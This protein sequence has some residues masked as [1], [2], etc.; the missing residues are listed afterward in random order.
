MTILFLIHKPQA[1]GQELFASLL[2]N[3]LL[4]LGHKVTL[5]SLYPGEFELPFQGRLLCIDS[6]SMGIK[7]LK[8]LSKRIAEI[9][10]DI[11]QANGGDTLK[12]MVLA[13]QLFPFKGKLIFNNGGVIGH[14]LSSEIHRIFYRFLL[15]RL[16]AAVSVSRFSAKDLSKWMPKNIPQVVIPIG[17]DAAKSIDLMPKVPNPVF[18]CIAGFTPEK[19][20]EF[21]ISAFT[22]FSQLHP[23]AQLWLI[24]DGP[25]KSKIEKLV[26][27]SE[28]GSMLFLGALT[29][30]WAAVPSNAVL[31]LPSKME[32]TPSVLAE[33]ALAKIP[34]VAFAVGGIAEMME[35][36]TS[37]NL[38][39]P[40]QEEDFLD[41][42]N[43][44]LNLE[45]GGKSSRLE[46]SKAMALE[47][48]SLDKVTRSFLEFYTQVCG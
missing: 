42:M 16:D 8:K 18:V 30:P 23:K 26:K 27:E 43:L 48:F 22:K 14:Y 46:A 32:G 47:R 34:S 15:S 41:A 17:V 35:G 1:R 10:P 40:D 5:L 31:L 9:Q 36:I 44:C 19:N 2:G 11:I 12:A 38:I 4:D 3:K 39:A 29:E 20:H 13:R 25:L 24:G 21:L 6:N 28:A 45:E 7:S 33:A 37:C